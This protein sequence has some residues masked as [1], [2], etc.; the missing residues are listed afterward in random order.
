MA[1]KTCCV[2]GHRDIPENKLTYVKEELKKHILQ[3]IEDGC[4]HFISGFAGG[5]DL[6]FAQIVADLKKENHTL[7][8][9]AA[10]PYEKRLES[11]NQQ[12]QVLLQVFD[13]IQVCSKEYTR[14]CFFIRNRYMV[15]DSKYVIAVYDGR[16]KGDTYYTIRYAH[17][18]KKEVWVIPL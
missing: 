2:T 9:E 15:D 3:A 6:I 5:S 7:S 4:T 17:Q 10:I 12:L 8:L 14:D 13:E 16:K 1:E 18:E 11:P